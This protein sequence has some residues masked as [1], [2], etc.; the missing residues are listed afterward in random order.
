MR[1]L[2]LLLLLAAA[3]GEKHPPAA[4]ELAPVR[5]KLVPAEEVG[6]RT[7]VPATVSAVDH[8][9]LA[10]RVSARIA[11]L[12]VAEGARVKR[13]DVLVR[14][15][16]D[17]VR[18]AIRAAVQAKWIGHEINSTQFVPPPRPMYSIGG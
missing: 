3:C 16:D 10:T 15:S 2:L 7:W 9:V 5:V 1:H 12:T 13:G 11:E 4:P 6:E 18:A 8:A 17:D 14:L